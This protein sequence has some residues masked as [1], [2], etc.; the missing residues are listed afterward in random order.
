MRINNFLIGIYTGN[1]CRSQR[2]S[3]PLGINHAVTIVGYGSEG[4]SNFWIVKNSW[5]TSWG[6][7]I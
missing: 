6:E 5:G 2:T 3:C 1:N 7:V 4:G